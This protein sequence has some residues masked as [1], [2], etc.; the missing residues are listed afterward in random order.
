MN[1]RAIRIG[2][3]PACFG[4]QKVTPPTAW[5][6]NAVQVLDAVADLGYAGIALGPPGFLGDGDKLR[7]RLVERNLVL[8]ESFLPF[9]FAQTDV[10]LDERAGL[11][12]VLTLLSDASTSGDKPIVA[13]SD[14]FLDP[15]RWP[16]A[17]RVGR[18]PEARLP[19]DQFSSFM[20][21]MHRIAEDCM[22]SGFQ[23]VLHHHA[24]TFV[25]TDVEIRNVLE[26]MDPSLIGLCLDTGHACFGGADPVRLA[27]DY[28]ELIR[29][30]HL[31]DAK[32]SVFTQVETEGLN[33]TMLQAAGAFC[34]LGEGDVDLVNVAAT[35]RRTNYKGWI[36]VEQDSIIFDKTDFPRIVDNQRRNKEF[37]K[38]VGFE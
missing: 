21:N 20:D 4:V 25:E 31:K 14:G 3:A 28:R 10:L 16:Y 17:G 23:P 1:A 8:A 5:K 11:G 6:P 34:P 30:V 32:R 26:A 22:V 24:G 35:L 18:F 12:A 7:K 19:A 29:H 33:F 36:I 13:L 2:S 38:S 15:R 27:E 9:H 37:L